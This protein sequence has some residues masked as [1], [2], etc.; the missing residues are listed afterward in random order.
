MVWNLKE[1]I[2]DPQNEMFRQLQSLLEYHRSIEVKQKCSF[3]ENK[4]GAISCH[5]YAE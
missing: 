3:L 5:Y 2:L 4:K 1:E